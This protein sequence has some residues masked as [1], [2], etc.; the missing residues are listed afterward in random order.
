MKRLS[1]YATGLFIFILGSLTLGLMAWFTAPDWG[2]M[3]HGMTMKKAGV[4]AAVLGCAFGMFL[5]WGWLRSAPKK[6]R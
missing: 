3:I 6:G 4:I 1:F 5:A 2:S